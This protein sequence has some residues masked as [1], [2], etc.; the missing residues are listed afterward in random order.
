MLSD[1]EGSLCWSF[2]Y[3]FPSLSAL[4]WSAI[5]Q[6]ERNYIFQ[7]R[8]LAGF[9]LGFVSVRHCKMKGRENWLPSWLW[10]LVASARAE[11]LRRQCWWW[12]QWQKWIRWWL[13]TRKQQ[14][15]RAGSRTPAQTTGLQQPTG[16]L[17]ILCPW[18]LGNTFAPVAQSGEV[19]NLWEI[20]LFLFCPS[21][22][23][24]TLVAISFI[25]YF[26]LKCLKLVFFPF[27]RSGTKNFLM[28]KL[29]LEKAEDPEIIL[30]TSVRS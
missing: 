1:Q 27:I 29:D 13:R 16:A 8:K 7:I 5:Y 3:C 9:C 17:G 18:V 12:R 10:F 28:F 21:I 19:N 20:T 14:P 24:S 11:Q 26:C 22:S 4:L 6:W 15:E 23:S 30:P 2:A 25:N